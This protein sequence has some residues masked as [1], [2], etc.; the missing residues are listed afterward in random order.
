MPDLGAF[1]LEG[2][3]AV[4]IGGAGA[5]GSAVAVGLGK[6][7][8][9]LVIADVTQEKANG[10]AADLSGEGLSASGEVVDALDRGSIEA[11]RDRVCS[12]HTTVDILVNLAGGNLPEAS[13]SD[14]RRFFDLPLD[15]FERTV[16]I[17]LLRVRSCRHRSSRKR[18]W[19]N[20]TGRPS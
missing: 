9:T 8:A 7:G 10:A 17:N 6:A 19:N 13:T 11:L 20:P 16:A 14:E 18:W 15:A 4:L 3:T 5:I 12:A 2:K 1:S